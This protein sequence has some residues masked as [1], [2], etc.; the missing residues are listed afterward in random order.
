M[1]GPDESGRRRL[2]DSPIAIVGLSGLFPRARDHRDYWQN[3]VDAVDCTDDLPEDRW[4]TTDHHD[5]DPSTPDKTYA[6][7][8]AFVPDVAFDP[9]EFGMPPNQLEIT[10]T[11]QT[12]SLVVARDL[13]RDAGAPGSDWYDPSRTGVVLGV[14]GT[15]PLSHPLA[16]RLSTP[17]LRE[18]A[19][20]CG[21]SEQDADVLADKYAKAFP[22]WEENTFPGLLAN[23]TAGRVANRLGLGGMNSTVDAACA[24]SLSAVRVAVAELVD[25][26][27]DLMIT[28]GC[29]T[30]TSLF[31]YMCFSKTRALS[32][33]DRIR[34][35]DESAD[36]TL[37]GEGIGMIALKRLADAER[38]GD[39]VYA[40]IR[41]IG[42]A[43][44]GRAKSIYAPRAEGQMLALQRAYADAD[45][46]PASV[47]LF[48]L[49]ATG[50]PVGDRTELEAL[51][52]VLRDAGAEPG[53]AAIGSVKSQIGHTKGAAGAA[54][55]IKLALSLHQ[56]T[57]P[58]TINVERPNPGALGEDAPVYVNT[59][60]RPW[61]KDPRRPVR[62][63]GT[64][65]MGFGGTNFHVV[66]E[67]HA[68]SR[69]GVPVLQRTAR[70]HL[71]H[72]P[73][74]PALVELLRAGGPGGDG[75]PVPADHV[76]IGFVATDGEADV[77]LRAAALA[78]LAAD[79]DAERWD[80]PAG[81][82]YR[83]SGL[84]DPKVGAL[85]S[86]QGSQYLEMGLDAALANP[87]VAGAFDDANA[88]FRAGGG[89][90]LADVVF[91]PPV[92]DADARD[93]QEHALHRTE[94]AQPAIGAL[95][96][97]QF[98]HLRELGLGV[99]GCLGHSFG[100]LTALWAAGSVG[101][102]DFFR[103]A[104]A[105]GEAMA[106]LDD[107]GD[108][109]AMA[110]VQ[111]GRDEVAALLAD[112]GDLLVCNDNAP[113]QVVIGGGADA[114]AA[115][116]AECGLRGLRARR[117][118]VSAAFHTP[119][120][121]HAL[122]RFR[123]AVDAAVIG[124][125]SVPVYANTS[126][127]RYGDDVDANRRT[128]VT[129]LSRPVE[130]ADALRA[131]H[132]DGC[133]VFVE[134]GP[135]QVLT[136]LVPRVLPDADVVAIPTD[137]GPL[138]DGDAALKQAA[139]RLA[140]LG[141]PL[142]GINRHDAPA[143]E[144]VEPGGPTITLNGADH[145]PESRRAAYREAIEDGYRV[146][147]ME[148]TPRTAEAAVPV[149]GHQW[150]PPAPVA[151]GHA[152]AAPDDALA[153]HLALHERYLDSQLRITEDLVGAVRRAADTGGDVD[154]LLRV[155][156]QVKEQSLGIGRTH[157]RANEVLAGLAG[158]GAGSAAPAPSSPVLL[159]AAPA[160]FAPAPAAATGPAAPAV[161]AVPETAV[162]ET[163]APNAVGPDTAREALVGIV[164]E[165][166]GYPAAMIDTG[167]DLEADLGID[168]IKRVQ[169]LDAVQSS[170]PGLPVL[171]PEQLG[172][173]RTLDD[174]VS[175]LTEGGDTPPVPSPA[176]STPTPSPAPVPAPD[177]PRAA[178]ELHRV[179]L[180]RLPAADRAPDVFR[181]AP[182]AL[183]VEHGGVGADADACAKALA[184]AGWTVHRGDFA[185]ADVPAGPLDLC[186][187]V[188]GTDT[189]WDLAVDRLAD[190]VALAGKISPRLA[191]TARGG[192]RTAF[193]TLTRLDGGLG[194]RGT[195]DRAEAVA[196][197]VAGI[198]KVLARE[199]PGVFCRALDLAPSLSVDAA[200]DT[201][202]AE[203]HDA[204]RD[205]LEVGVD[206]DLARW[207][208]RP[209][210]YGSSPWAG[211]A[212][213]LSTD[214]ESTIGPD[215][216]VVVTGG[217]RGVTA[218]CVR[219]LAERTGAEFVLLGRTDL[220]DEPD[221]ALGVTDDAL[222][223]ALA[224]TGTLS[225]REFT[226]AVREV[227]ARREV[228]AT[229]T[230]VADAGARV[231]YLGVDVGDATA[232]RDALAPH[233]ER[234]TVLVHG[235]GALAD[236]LL[237]DKTPED[238]RRVFTPKLTG[239][240]S[241]LDALAGA[242]LRH[243]VFFTSVAGLLG[244]PGQ[245]DY[246]AANEAL[247]RVAA[248]LKRERPERFVTAVDWCAWDGGMVGPDLRAVFAARG[249][250]LLAPD[251]GARLFVER[252]AAGRAAEARLLAGTPEA[253]T[254]TPAP[255]PT[256][257][258]TAARDLTGVEDTEVIRAH[259]IGAH[260]V[261]PATFGLGWLVN[262]AERAN[263]GLRVVA[264]RGFEVHRGVVFDGDHEREY[265]VDLDPGEVEDGRLVLRARVRAAGG[266]APIARSHYAGTLVL[267][268]GDPRTERLPEV[269]DHVPGTGPDDALAWYA[270]GTVFHGPRLQGMRRLLDRSGDRLVVECRLA[271]DA[272][273][274]GAFAGHRYSAVLTDLLLQCG[275]VLGLWRT[276]RAG[277][278]LG[279]ELVECFAP[280]PDDEPFVVVAREVRSTATSSTVDV[281]A[282]NRDG[283]VLMRLSGVSVIQ[284]ADMA[285]KF[286]DAV[287]AWRDGDGGGER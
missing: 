100:E 7:R 253:L 236:A 15:V 239:L 263:P 75:G 88:L 37:L 216:V 106:P 87:T 261:L 90:S 279:V 158:L 251:T 109:G 114:V 202:L 173:L 36:G 29:D 244:N 143:P 224:R 213:P 221:W 61:I 42:S 229:L 235:A 256:P 220:E 77:R 34:P 189:V 27:A 268:A 258:L 137:A 32:R 135:K 115:F 184:E 20:S 226:A 144:R 16:A 79:P 120:V 138:G 177:A 84:V 193:A 74:V 240:R 132:A 218:A 76:R 54:S 188:L 214:G 200:A 190:V 212:T 85:F 243:V 33:S 14:T 142:T 23:V 9:I 141:V 148:A 99:A 5:P 12:L 208:V 210:P 6:R 24:A 215:D 38:D 105:R 164:A 219:A 57:L 286:A 204:A 58:P 248:T 185:E 207:T 108:R 155:V 17:V 64:S 51:T 181:E 254:G 71:W 140:V 197:G 171:G 205:V 4:S 227:R 154:A 242:P 262:V 145:V 50:T 163:A 245:A 149:N 102:E 111:T 187:V 222:P 260:P 159:P 178:A 121:A 134:F 272:A 22:P 257:A 45:C 278:P 166:T 68:P 168:S 167:M 43:S 35:L 201:V 67:E 66:L 228:A 247:C 182:T 78:Q 112:F 118:P 72:A 11:M 44:D 48:E 152:P 238:V 231:T 282:C 249:V 139:L 230:A 126:G 217:A 147:T 285:A 271:D 2:A 93:R 130:F 284:T 269:R 233:A 55:L 25:G 241:V 203:L 39:R 41:G 133:S 209:A 103:L 206:G 40:V 69:E 31:M 56:K 160:P 250:D 94:W 82:H 198:V 92:F 98:R 52:S 191:E 127:A 225:P 266:A 161:P 8:G 107:D 223:D 128:L 175:Y 62:R 53:S 116:V 21:L 97:G 179:E 287:S 277:L 73:D 232:V 281:T 180:V 10:S 46:S 63:A 131:M 259:R 101:D 125:P 49:H 170:L 95:S 26:R 211:A 280:L 153:H 113:D 192:T 252:F 186:L 30:E 110:A 59:A 156:E 119:Y 274:S 174:I 1:N 91:P 60:T 194:L 104:C 237:P 117:L 19:V 265:A 136:Q 28:G 276:G 176:T 267:A 129:Q 151:A 273:G 124:S 18:V 86:G 89:A 195:R 13:L 234:A 264:C 122:D 196:G 80:H 246:A 270:D 255:M 169:I 47:Q 157:T 275:A 96:A 283:T 83:R 65:A 70:A 199:E 150:R 146:S 183:L 123:P 81:I 172:E 165:R 162:P 3:I